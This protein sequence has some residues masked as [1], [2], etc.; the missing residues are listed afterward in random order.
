MDRKHMFYSAIQVLREY[1]SWELNL[2][3]CGIDIGDTAVSRLADEILKILVDYNYEWDYDPIE[4]FGW[5]MEYCS[6][7]DF[8]VIYNNYQRAGRTWN[9]A[10]AMTL[11]DFLVYM[12]EHNWER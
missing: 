10:D 5:I 3:R 7:C 8:D 11:Y 6:K 2:Y 9:L 4:D 12:N 1:T